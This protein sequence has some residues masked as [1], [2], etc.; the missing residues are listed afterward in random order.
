MQAY[1]PQLNRQRFDEIS[2]DSVKKASIVF[3]WLLLC[4]MAAWANKKS[5]DDENDRKKSEITM[6][7][8][9]FQIEFFVGSALIIIS[10][11]IIH[12]RTQPNTW[13]RAYLNGIVMIVSIVFFIYLYYCNLALIVEMWKVPAESS[14]AQKQSLTD[15]EIKRKR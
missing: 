5:V 1:Q 8:V 6:S 12:H 3:I 13:K 9:L 11:Y 7:L 10:L 4:F 15:F 14:T 2:T